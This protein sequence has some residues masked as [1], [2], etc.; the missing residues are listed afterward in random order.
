MRVLLAAALALLAASF[1]R[2]VAAVAPPGRRRPES[3]SAAGAVR[4]APGAATRRDGDQRPRLVLVWVAVVAPDQPSR[5]TLGGFAR[6]PLELL[7]V[8]AL[9]A[10][11]A[12]TAPRRVLAVIAGRC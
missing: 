3:R 11:A 10:S 5:L 9:Q 2:R 4:P 12:P 6:L 1:R 8:V 7:A